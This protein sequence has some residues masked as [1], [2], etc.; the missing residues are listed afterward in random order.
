MFFKE[1]SQVALQFFIYGTL[2]NTIFTLLEFLIA[3]LTVKLGTAF[4]VKSRW[5]LGCRRTS[6][7]ALIAPGGIAAFADVESN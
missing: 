2:A 6:G 3:V 1:D 4:A 5:M 7:F